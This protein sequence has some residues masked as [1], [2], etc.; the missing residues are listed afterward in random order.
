MD[1]VLIESQYIGNCSYWSALLSAE[2]I[3]LDMHEHFAKRSYRNRAHILG[4]NGLLRLTIPLQSGKHQHSA[5]KDVRISYNENWQ[6]LHWQSLTSAYR[7]SPFFEFYEDELKC[8]YEEREE[9]L[10][11]FNCKLMRAIASIL[12]INLT[13]EFTEKYNKE[14]GEEITDI[15]SRFMPG[16]HSKRNFASYPQVFSDRFNFIEDLS[17]FDLLFNMGSRS[18]D[19]LRDIRS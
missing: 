18:A 11:E 4:A 17:V 2:K 8:F 9:F 19:Y 15:R 12:K 10:L 5:M 14:A 3:Q 7:R 16:K 6:K 1:Q 13:I